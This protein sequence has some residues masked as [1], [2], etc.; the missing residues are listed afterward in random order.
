MAHVMHVLPARETGI[1]FAGFRTLPAAARWRL[2]GWLADRLEPTREMQRALME[3]PRDWV[4]T[5][6]ESGR[7][8]SIWRNVISAAREAG[9]GE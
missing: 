6:G 5:G 9:D 2:I 4:L 7:A 1:A 3:R 8:I